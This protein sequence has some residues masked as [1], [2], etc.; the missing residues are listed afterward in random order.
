VSCVRRED[1]DGCVRCQDGKVGC[2]LRKK[3]KNA[4]DDELFEELLAEVRGMRAEFKGAMELMAAS[5]ERLARIGTAWWNR[6]EAREQVGIIWGTQPDRSPVVVTERMV[7]VEDGVEEGSGGE[8]TLQ[9]EMAV[10]PAAGPS[11]LA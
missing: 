6:E 7:P 8:E 9:E 3:K 11:H 1:G 5:S 2:S 10:D 4:R